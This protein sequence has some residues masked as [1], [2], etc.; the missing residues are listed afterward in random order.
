MNKIK[1]V[2]VVLALAI[3]GL[4]PAMEA[5]AL[6]AETT[7]ETLNRAIDKA[8]NALVE[9]SSEQL[10]EHKK[11]LQNLV[12]QAKSM[13]T[14]FVCN[15]DKNL[16]ELEAALDEGADVLMLLEQS[17]KA[18]MAQAKTDTE[19]VQTSQE[20]QVALAVTEVNVNE[21]KPEQVAETVAQNV[22][23]NVTV[24]P[25]TEE[26]SSDE[27]KEDEKQ[28]ADSHEVAQE[29]DDVEIPK[30]GVNNEAKT[31]GLVIGGVVVIAGAMAVLITR[32]V[33]R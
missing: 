19:K 10:A 18:M 7:E 16:E 28:V 32:R 31:V 5:G 23:V 12:D 17:E 13:M 3:C 2:S 6:A 22:Q 20:P 26:N 24:E 14:C 25:A 29:T 27:S 9:T 21:E 33:K 4:M 8:E 11:Y 1:I 30:T 15:R